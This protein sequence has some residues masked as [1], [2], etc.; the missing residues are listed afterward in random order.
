[1]FITSL[2]MQSYGL[3]HSRLL[4]EALL[5]KQ[6]CLQTKRF[7]SKFGQLVR[8]SRFPLATTKEENSDQ[9][10]SAL[11][12]ETGTQSLTLFPFDPFGRH[13]AFYAFPYAHVVATKQEMTQ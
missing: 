9:T 8:L 7:L 1:M 6:L 13:G 5:I 12:K 2:L 3:F 10:A 4:L 11:D